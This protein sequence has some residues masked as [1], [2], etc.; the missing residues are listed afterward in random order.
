MASHKAACWDPYSVPYILLHSSLLYPYILMFVVISDGI[1]IYLSFSFELTS[2]FPVIESC[3]DIFSWVISNKLS[4][5]PNE[6]EYLLFNPKHVTI[7]NCNINIDFNII[8][9]NDSAKNLGFIFQSDMSMNKHISAIVKSCFLQLCNFHLACPF[10]SKTT[11]IILANAFVHSHLDYCNCL[12]YGLPKYSVPRLKKVQNRTTH[13]I[14]HTFRF[15]HIKPILKFLLW[16]LEIYRINFKIF[17]LTHHA[18][19]LGELI[20]ITCDLCSLIDLIL[21]L[22]VPHHLTPFL[23]PVSK[24]FTMVF[25]LC[26]LLHLFFGIIHL[27]LFVLLLHTYL[28]EENLKQLFNQAFPT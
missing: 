9:P 6:M 18:L 17:C 22:C 1:Q 13:I 5:N 24:N 28:L 11:A 23:Y 8:T 20:H 27:T 15:S 19:S 4:V 25:A 21:T 7:P 3:R 12:F 2:V 16:L 26:L 10:I 14:A